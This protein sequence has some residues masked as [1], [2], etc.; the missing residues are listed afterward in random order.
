MHGRKSKLNQDNMNLIFRK[1]GE[2]ETHSLNWF[3]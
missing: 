3:L 1:A 2:S